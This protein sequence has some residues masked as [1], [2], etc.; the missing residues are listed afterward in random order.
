MLVQTLPARPATASGLAPEV[1]QVTSSPGSSS[2]A[3]A[4]GRA[5]IG[6]V[7]ASGIVVRKMRA[8]WR[9]REILQEYSN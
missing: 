1:I 9:S 6:A 8:V 2:L 7:A 3:A 4:C 5:R